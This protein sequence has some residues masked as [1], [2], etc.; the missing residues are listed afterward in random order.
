MCLFFP[1]VTED[2]SDL[3]VWGFFLGAVR[4][5]SEQCPCWPIHTW[6][7]KTKPNHLTQ[8]SRFSLDSHLYCQHWLILALSTSYSLSQTRVQPLSPEL[9]ACVRAD[10]RIPANNSQQCL[11]YKDNSDLAYGLLHPPSECLCLW[12][13]MCVVLRETV[14]PSQPVLKS[15]RDVSEHIFTYRAN[16][17]F[18]AAWEKSIHFLLSDT[19]RIECLFICFCISVFWMFRD[20]NTQSLW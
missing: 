11:R 16:I 12:T 10:V 2:G 1:S 9:E 15:G 6:R 13:C 8:H 14:H 19:L 4:T 3:L 17:C 5:E 18:T 20:K 7:A